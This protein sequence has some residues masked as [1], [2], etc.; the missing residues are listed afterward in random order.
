MSSLWSEV[1]AKD[2]PAAKVVRAPEYR[3]GS[4]FASLF[5]G[6][7]TRRVNHVFPV[8]PGVVACMSHHN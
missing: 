8:K 2:G 5:A 7:D 4:Q 1:T 6:P 3:R